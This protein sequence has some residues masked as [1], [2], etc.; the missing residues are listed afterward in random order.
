MEDSVSNTIPNVSPG[1]SALIF[2]PTLMPANASNLNAV[3]TRPI[4]SR[5]YT[6]INGSSELGNNTAHSMTNQDI[7]LSNVTMAALGTPVST[8]LGTAII[9]PISTPVRMYCLF[10]SVLNE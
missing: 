6:V 10:R 5:Q 3:A 2:T 7:K 1:T 9:L 4:V 8:S